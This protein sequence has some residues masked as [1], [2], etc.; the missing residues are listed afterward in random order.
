MSIENELDSSLQITIEHLT[1]RLVQKMEILQQQH[2]LPLHRQQLLT[3]TTTTMPRHRFD[4]TLLISQMP[5]L[6][7]T[8]H[9]PNNNVLDDMPKHKQH[10]LN[11]NYAHDSFSKVLASFVRKQRQQLGN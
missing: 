10:M 1:T 8:E 3:T 6:H 4:E 7:Q 5:L 2:L 11:N 9:V